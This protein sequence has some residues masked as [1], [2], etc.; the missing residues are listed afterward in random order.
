MNKTDYNEIYARRRR[1]GSAD[2]LKLLLMPFV[3]FVFFGFPTAAGGYIQTLSNFAAPAFFILSGFFILTPDDAVR[4]KRLKKAIKRNFITFTAMFIVYFLIN[5][6]YL[7]YLGVNWAPEILRKRIL[8]NFLVFNVWP[9]SIGGGIWFMQ[10]LLF[11]VI[12]LLAADICKLLKKPYVY[13]PV[14][15]ILVCVTLFSGEF[16]RLAGFPHFGYNYI[17]AG[18]VTRALP[19]MLIGMFIRY[20]ANTILNINRWLF[21]VLFAVGFLLAAAELNLL[22]HF[23]LLI[24][25]GH[26]VGFAIM[27]ISACCF[28]LSLTDTRDSFLTSHGRSFAKRIYVCCQPVYF[29]MMFTVSYVLPEYYFVIRA[30]SPF[31][32]LT[33]CLIIAYVTGVVKFA[34][35]EMKKLDNQ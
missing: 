33:I 2:T 19:Y 24:Y 15:L 17:P 18:T 35:S 32:V 1:V 14:F 34:L 28:A 16:S 4:R 5:A 27:A 26:T 10:S 9:L 11:A 3:M 30:F 13:I 6:A 29:I 12:I 21:P 25:T 31:I 8:F 22:A 23:K 7:S 20:K